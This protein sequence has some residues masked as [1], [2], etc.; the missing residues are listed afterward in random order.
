MGSPQLRE[1]TSHIKS[2]LI[3][4]PQGVGK[5]MLVNAICTELGATLFDLTATNIVGR[6]IPRSLMPIS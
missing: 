4:G 6:S 2:I 1:N 5:T 3:A